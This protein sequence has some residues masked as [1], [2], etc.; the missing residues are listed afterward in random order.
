M[1]F[2]K[3]AI[4][5][6]LSLILLLALA[7]AA[8]LADGPAFEITG[9]TCSGVHYNGVFENQWATVYIDYRT[10]EI[11]PIYTDQIFRVYRDASAEGEPFLEEVFHYKAAVS[12][13]N[14]TPVD[15]DMPAGNHHLELQIPFMA[16]GITQLTVTLQIGE[17]TVA[18]TTAADAV[19]VKPSG[20]IELS[21]L[22]LPGDA[23][24]G[25]EGEWLTPEYY[26]PNGRGPTVYDL[27]AF[28]D[29][30]TG[31]MRTYFATTDGIIC[32]DEMGDM[33]TMPGTDGILFIA[34]GGVDE[35]SLCAVAMKD[36]YYPHGVHEIYQFADGVWSPVENSAVDFSK[37]KNQ[38]D[39]A[40][41]LILSP[42]EA[43]NYWY[44][45]DGTEWTEHS[46]GFSSFWHDSQG[47]A[48]AAGG[49]ANLGL[50]CYENGEWVL[51]RQF[52]EEFEGVYISS[53]SI[54]SSIPTENGVKLLGGCDA[55]IR[56]KRGGYGINS[57]IFTIENGEVS[58]ELLR[59]SEDEF[60]VFRG[61]Y[62]SY[63]LCGGFFDYN[64]DVVISNRGLLASELYRR[65]DGE[66]VFQYADELY[67]DA[68]RQYFAEGEFE[69]KTRPAQV[70]WSVNPV[71]GVTYVLG[72]YGTVYMMSDDRTIT[73]ETNGGTEVEPLTAPIAS[74][75]T[76]PASPVRDGYTFVGWYTLNDFMTNGPSYAFGLMPAKD[77]TL[78][79]KWIEA[80][81][82]EDPFAAD[83]ERAVASLNT[84][85][86]K[87][88]PTEYGEDV[89]AQIEAAYEA[90]LAN[91]A[92]ATTYDG[93][94]GAL[95]EALDVIGELARQVSGE[96]NVAFTMESFTVD[97]EYIIEPM[98]LTVPK[99]EQASVVLTDTLKEQFGELNGGTPFRMTGTVTNSFYLQGV[100][101]YGND[102][103]ETYLGE[104]EHGDD[105][106]WM[107]CVNG[108][109]PGV[110][111]SSYSLLN[112]D[113]MRWQYT[114]VGLGADI[115]NSWDGTAVSVADK[116]ALIWKIAEINAAGEQEEYPTY[117][118]AMAV[119]KDIPASQEA[120]DAAL[121]AL[122]KAEP[123][124]PAAQIV[125][126]SLTLAGDI[127]VN[128][129]VIPNDELL[130]DEGAYAQLT[131]KGV[132]GDKIMLADLT[133]DN[134][135]RFC[136]TQFVAAKEMTEQITLAI[137]TGEDEAV[138]LTDANGD[139]SDGVYSVARFVRTA[140]EFGS[141][142]LQALSAKLASYGAYAKAY[143]EYEP[144]TEDTEYADAIAGDITGDITVE[145]VTPYK[146]VKDA[147]TDAFKAKSISL[148]LKS[149]TILNV[150][151]T[152]T[153]AA[154]YSFTVDGEP[155]SAVKSGANYV[156][157]IPDIAAQDL[158]K[159]YTI[160]ATNG[161][162][163]YTISAYALTYAYQVI[164][165]EDRTDAIRDLVKA[166]YEYNQAAN[167]YFA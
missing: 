120:V 7:P 4:A 2:G 57:L 145:T 35:A 67:D 66:W 65:V 18:Y 147:S 117:G 101:Y 81:S 83:R 52:E 77:I 43:W 84:E 29:E 85:F 54:G 106:G 156:V 153:D 146:P 141:E 116:D 32:R 100:Y 42:T 86:E 121:A 46:Y 26:T 69:K 62:G 99:Y 119:L 16:E 122:V 165:A 59:Q 3:K 36:G 55:N 94:Y 114:C 108:D 129:F 124:G 58:A 56:A 8:A 137:Y 64:G 132:T 19:T 164:K 31:A 50:Y 12:V 150:T 40:N 13:D 20:E 144:V 102:G 39:D 82:G 6:F 123:A 159:A 110:G 163:T 115:G 154:Q 93:V 33:R 48:W 149:E 21:Y 9:V 68:D 38:S 87:L 109:F 89:W 160:V 88:D 30:E 138:A 151:F 60:K 136:F 63:D 96:I 161:D 27:L 41:A 162:S 53:P 134:D 24:K 126:A 47:H 127:G 111:A 75:I 23:Y 91:I 166:L 143:F 28:A 104:K 79:A 97:G 5:M 112:G 25:L 92:A 90:G 107:Y 71:E 70:N 98:L 133:P 76:P 105:S 14:W 80:G 152:G 157:Q 1:R 17:E 113:V 130:A 139:A 155:V 22:R 140:A 15:M 125:S 74:N 167:A 142:K 148:T 73:F 72:G 118:D 95:N 103:S 37:A 49:W 61:Q 44:H 158:D 45:W 34:L 10:E 11:V 131:V 135:G 51:L 78:Y 128:F